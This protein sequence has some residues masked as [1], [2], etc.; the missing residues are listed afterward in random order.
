M[1]SM[2][3]TLKKL[4]ILPALCLALMLATAVISP[5]AVLN[6]SSGV[7]MLGPTIGEG[8][9]ATDASVPVTG[10]VVNLNNGGVATFM[11]GGAAK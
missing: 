4:P 10:G 3:K 11:I 9:A 2:R 1:M 6:I 7:A 5:A 8:G